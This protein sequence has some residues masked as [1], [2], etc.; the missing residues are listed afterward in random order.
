MLAF[1]LTPRPIPKTAEYDPVIR[2]HLGRSRLP[3][4][5][6]SAGWRRFRLSCLNINRNQLHTG[7]KCDHDPRSRFRFFGT[8]R[9]IWK[10]SLANDKD[11]RRCEVENE[12]AS[13]S[14]WIWKLPRR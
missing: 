2:L 4:S 7:L 8:Y 1:R 14:T 3:R 12:V 11:N 6:I 13:F 10:S 5:S 9:A